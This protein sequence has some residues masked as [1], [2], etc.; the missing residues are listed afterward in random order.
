MVDGVDGV[1]MLRCSDHPSFQLREQFG[2]A[3]LQLIQCRQTLPLLRLVGECFFVANECA[4]AV[5]AFI[6]MQCA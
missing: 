2:L 4:A 5:V 3:C 1:R 6:I